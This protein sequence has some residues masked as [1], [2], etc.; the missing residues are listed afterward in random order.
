MSVAKSFPY[1]AYE[2]QIVLLTEE[3]IAVGQSQTPDN[4]TPP[5]TSHAYRVNHMVEFAPGD[6][7]YT[8]ATERSGMKFRGQVDLGLENPGEMTMTLAEIDMQLNALA[9]DSRVVE[10]YSLGFTEGGNNANNDN[11][12]NVGLLLTRGRASRDTATYGARGFGHIFIP[13][14]TL[15]AQHAGANQTGGEN[16]IPLTYVVRPSLSSKLFNGVLFSAINADMYTDGQTWW[17]E[18][19][20]NDKLAV[21]S[22]VA[23][24]S[25]ATFTL[26]YRALYSDATAIGRNR[27]ARVDNG[28][29]TGNQV[30]V[31]S[32]ATGSSK[33]VTLAAPGTSG[34]IWNIIYPTTFTE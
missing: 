23:D 2:V 15:R 12:P 4:I 22:F 3:G 29:A 30:A 13:N 26:G 28:A 32:I 6:P 8:V 34:D 17:H 24:G 9:T 14:C 33:L 31:T 19:D 10:D 20:T 5:L 1:G 18:V 25:T 11:P 21:T 27:I 7:T 16:P